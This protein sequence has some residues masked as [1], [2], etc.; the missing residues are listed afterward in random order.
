M[1]DTGAAV[2][3]QAGA[4]PLAADRRKAKGRSLPQRLL[5]QA[6]ARLHEIKRGPA[7]ALHCLT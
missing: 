3:L 2:L 1:H 7:P 6:A 5:R 4:M